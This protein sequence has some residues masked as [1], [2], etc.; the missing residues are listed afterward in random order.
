MITKTDILAA[1]IKVRDT[2]AFHAYG[3]ICSN[4]HACLKDVDPYIGL[5]EVEDWLQSYFKRWPEFSG[6][7]HY[8]VDHPGMTPER[9][10]HCTKWRWDT[11]TEYGKARWRLLHFLIDEL[12]QEIR[13]SQ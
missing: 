8:P 7:S 3:G 9:A 11:E 13:N 2:D 1:L 4:A 10:Y 5:G 6:N 12:E